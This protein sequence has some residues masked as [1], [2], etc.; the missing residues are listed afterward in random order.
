MSL[1]QENLVRQFKSL[2]SKNDLSSLILENTRF[3]IFDPLTTLHLWIYQ[4]TVVSSSRS[5]FVFFNSKRIANGERPV[6]ICSSA[7]S[8]AEK[9]QRNKI[10]G[11]SGD[12][13][14]KGLERCRELLV[15]WL[16]SSAF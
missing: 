10:G 3:R 14:N 6:N 1:C 13:L 5:A 15:Q 12:G 7:F 4:I 9:R 16:K 8:R 11:T 2:I